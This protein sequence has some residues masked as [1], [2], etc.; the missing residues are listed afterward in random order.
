MYIGYTLLQLVHKYEK[1]D[2]WLGI[3]TPVQRQL[4][5]LLCFLHVTWGMSAGSIPVSPF[6]E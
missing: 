3:Y 2:A 4:C 5:L 6:T 1:W